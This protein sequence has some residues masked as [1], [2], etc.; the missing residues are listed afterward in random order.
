M[1]LV[2]RVKGP[3]LPEMKPDTEGGSG[4]GLDVGVDDWDI[5]DIEL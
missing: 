5:I 3:T 1:D 2:I 4:G